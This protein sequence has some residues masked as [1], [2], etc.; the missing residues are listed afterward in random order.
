M[1]LIPCALECRHQ[2]EGYCGLETTAAVTNT[3]GGCPY[4][5]KKQVGAALGYSL[6][7]P[8]APA[9]AE[10]GCP[11]YAAGLIGGIDDPLSDPEQPEPRAEPAGE[12][13][14]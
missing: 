13:P 1:N 4:F 12:D 5:V 9:F 8:E 14:S 2:K 3:A 6:R 11:P 7:L 10:G